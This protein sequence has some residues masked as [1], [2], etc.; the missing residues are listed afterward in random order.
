MSPRI[1]QLKEVWILLFLLGVTMLNYPFLHIFNKDVLVFGFP[2]LF[3]Y[4]ML[5]WPVSI[6][7][8]YYFSRN[9]R[10]DATGE[11]AGQEK[12]IPG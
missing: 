2:L 1:S 9:M 12:D 3:L 7:I 6:S 10:E 4:F 11:S 8:V 5:G